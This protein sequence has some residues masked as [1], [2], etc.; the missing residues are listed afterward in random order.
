VFWTRWLL[1]YEDPRPQCLHQS[2]RQSC[3]EYNRKNE[4]SMKEVHIW[5]NVSWNIVFLSER[6]LNLTLLV[7]WFNLYPVLKIVCLNYDA[8]YTTFKLIICIFVV[9]W[10]YGS[11]A[12]TFLHGWFSSNTDVLLPVE[13]EFLCIYCLVNAILNQYFNMVGINLRKIDTFLYI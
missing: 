12:D 6:R 3:P 1:S 8:T 9:V 7:I 2:L 10:G 4:M 13:I 5:T 11:S